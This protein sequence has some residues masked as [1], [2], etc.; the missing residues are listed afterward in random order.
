MPPMLKLYAK[1]TV[2]RLI[3]QYTKPSYVIQNINAQKKA[4]ETYGLAGKTIQNTGVRQK[5]RK[6]R[7]VTK[8]SNRN[9]TKRP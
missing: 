3:L 6:G 1:S 5:N 9:Y 7:D 8:Y 2:N 4:P